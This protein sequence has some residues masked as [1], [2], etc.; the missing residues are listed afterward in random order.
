MFLLRG[1]QAPGMK[2]S[3]KRRELNL[4][5]LEHSLDLAHARLTWC[6]KILPDLDLYIYI[7]IYKGRH[8][9]LT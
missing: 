1:S 7:Y 8:E 9:S 2:C 6:M 5:A 3:M 4:P